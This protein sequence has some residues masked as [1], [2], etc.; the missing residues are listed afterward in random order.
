M[1]LLL[2]QACCCALLLL[3][4][5]LLDQAC[6]FALLLLLLQWLQLGQSCAQLVACCLTTVVSSFTWGPIFWEH[7]SCCNSTWEL[8]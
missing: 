2:A 1:L 3:W 8:L 6:R 7:G 5:L 4:L